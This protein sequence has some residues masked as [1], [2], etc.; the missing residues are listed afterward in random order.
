M[1]KYELKGYKYLLDRMDKG[2]LVVYFD[3]D[4]GTYAS[5]GTIF[6]KVENKLLNVEHFNRNLLQ[7][8]TP[9]VSMT[10]AGKQYIGTK[11]CIVVKD[12]DGEYKPAY[13]NKKVFT[14]VF[15]NADRYSYTGAVKDDKKI[16]LLLIVHN[17]KEIGGIMAM[18]T[19]GEDK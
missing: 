16:R 15:G 6:F 5:D 18:N 14:T 19:W 3:R 7:G 11:E 4:D 12:L 2:D 10:S 1:N 8:F 13:I 9:V 17:G